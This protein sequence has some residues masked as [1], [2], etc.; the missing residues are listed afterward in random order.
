MNK[1]GSFYFFKDKEIPDIDKWQLLRLRG[2]DALSEKAQLKL[3]WIIFYHTLGGSNALFTAKHF[4]INPKTFHKWKKRF[5]ELD[6]STLEEDSRAPNKTRTRDI[7]SLQR[8]QIRTLRRKHMRWGKMKLR[9]I[10]FKTYGEYVSSWKIQKVIE[11]EH[12]YFDKV[13]HK[14]EQRRRKQAQKQQ[15]RRITE[16]VKENKVNHLWHVDTIIF[17]LS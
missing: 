10:Y 14:K 13:K 3:E 6:L 2:K 16:F 17:T 4:G 7:S 8:V 11:E 1:S 12:L 5:N 9:K 15:K